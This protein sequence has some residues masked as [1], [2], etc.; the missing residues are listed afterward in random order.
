MAANSTFDPF[1]Q[2]LTLLDQNGNPIPI[3]IP[4]LDDF[5]L[6]S[7]QISINYSAQLAASLI[8]LVVLAIVTKPEKRKSPVFIFNCASQA[9]NFGRNLMQC[10]Y[11][12]GPF[13]EVYAYFAFDYSRVPES[14]YAVSI[15]A[16]ICNM[17]LMVFVEA[18]LML[19]A[20]VVCMT[21]PKLHR[22]VILFTSLVIGSLALVFRLILTIEN[23]KYILSLASPTSLYWLVSS[24]NIVTTVSICWFCAV[25]VLKL[26]FALYQRRKLG[27]RRFG[28]M[29]VLFIMGCNTLFIPGKSTALELG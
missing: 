20:Q 1:N 8:L 12:T 25:F 4:E 18:S 22:Q 24:T 9:L 6:Y 7:V 14:A 11:F 2:T 3:T 29:Q 26:C 15:A 17:L 5:I 13:S 23:T 28:P 21:L 10:L 19:Q 27:L 16:L